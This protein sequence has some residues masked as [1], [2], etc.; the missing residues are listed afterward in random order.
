[1]S[2]ELG[3]LS[4]FD[5]RR[6]QSNAFDPIRSYYFVDHG[7]SALRFID[8]NH[9]VTGDR[10]GGL[11]H[12]D[13]RHSNNS[14]TVSRSECHLDRIV[15][16]AVHPNKLQFATGG[17]GHIVNVW[18]VRNQQTPMFVLDHHSSAVRALDWCPWEHNILATGGGLD[19]GR[20]C[21]IDTHLGKMVKSTETG[22]QICK[23]IW[24]R[25]YK[26]IVSL[27]STDAEQI[28][29]RRYPDID[30]VALH[31]KGH[32]A[33]PLHSSLSPDGQ[34]LATMSGDETVKLWRCFPVRP[35][36]RPLKPYLKEP[37]STVGTIR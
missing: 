21:I 12:W 17:N 32:N 16:I 28:E 27:A 29:I 11:H 2:T 1:M 4:I 5:I 22:F 3:F 13:L 9:I 7:V 36:Q 37:K 8:N 30:S 26:E 15:S 20:I 24:S 6:V 35:D 23:L 25:H 31:F 33:R 14:P 10:T 18:D 34:V 19:D